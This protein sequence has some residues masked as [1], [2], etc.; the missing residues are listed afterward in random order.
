MNPTSREPSLS[1]NLSRGGESKNNLSRKNY[2][3]KWDYTLA[4]SRWHFDKS[5]KSEIDYKVF[6]KVAGDWQRE[7]E[8]LQYEIKVATTNYGFKGTDHDGIIEKDFLEWGYQK[9]MVQ[10]DRTYQLPL[11]F[12]RLG[13]ALQ[14]KH[15]DMRI[16]RQR[17]GMVAPIHIDTY[18]SHPA[19]E[20]DPSLDVSLLRRFVIQLTPWDWGHFWQFGNQSWTHWEAGD[21]A[22]FE[23]RDVLHCTANAGK[24]DRVTMIV[25]GWMTEDTLAMVE[26]DEPIRLPL[27]D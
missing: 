17:P 3:S 22:Y 13:E 27:L 18:C 20:K 23:S 8:E 4:V 2:Q 6:L 15:P 14:L 11:K 26:S 25:T 21:V 5:R 9:D 16:H 24:T 1:K 7:L 19:M 12:Q 10:Y